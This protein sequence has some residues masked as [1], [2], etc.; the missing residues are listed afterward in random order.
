MD[1]STDTVTSEQI[2][3]PSQGSIV[4][5]GISSTDEA[6]KMV[7]GFQNSHNLQA[8]LDREE[9][10]QARSNSRTNLYGY[11]GDFLR[12]A[13]KLLDPANL[14]FL[15]AV[16]DAH[17]L[18]PAP[19]GANP[20][21][22]LAKVFFGEWKDVEY[23]SNGKAKTR[24]VP[25]EATKTRLV[26]GKKQFFLPNRTAEKYAKAA[27][28]A[29]S[30]GWSSDRLTE[31]LCGGKGGLKSIIDADTAATKGTDP[32][33][34]YV[35]RLVDLVHKA[36]PLHILDFSDC[37]IGPDYAERKL[38]SLW[39]EIK[40]DE[41]LIRGVLPT[42]ESALMAHVRKYAKENGAKLALSALEEKGNDKSKAQATG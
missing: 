1:N 14:Q 28:Y 8:G 20:F 35:E 31:E 40:D 34:K 22:P 11:V 7:E 9:I 26:D 25:S 6:L 5:L 19:T 30:K 18:K 41:V 27:R 23:I 24:K 12:D 3:N 38:V 4:N 16:L 29:N 21:G 10:K 36:E 2:T 37:G 15:N 13:G 39:A 33:E 17:G 42:S 32:D